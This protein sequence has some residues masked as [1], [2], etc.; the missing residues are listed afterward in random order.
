V[1]AHLTVQPDGHVRL[2]IVPLQSPVMTTSP[3]PA[4]KKEDAT[5]CVMK[6]GLTV[7]PGGRVRLCVAVAPAPPLRPLAA[8][9]EAGAKALR[10]GLA[11]AA[12]AVCGK[13]S[14][15]AAV[16]KAGG[17][18]KPAAAP[19]AGGA[20]KATASPVPAAQP[21]AAQAF[22][23]I[24]AAIKAPFAKARAPA[25]PAAADCAAGADAVV[26]LSAEPAACAKAAA[27]AAAAV[28]KPKPR[29]TATGREAR[30]RSLER[31]EE[32]GAQVSSTFKD[33]LSF[34]FAVSATA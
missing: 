2:A 34:H 27:S 20:R 25:A 14:K 1:A 6:A 10:T 4:A 23:K 31:L 12:E 11:R 3:K 17:S 28:P 21:K 24:A 13:A 15:A 8:A 9:I 22:S 16:L 29:A 5:P 26:L 33:T 32:F 19:A 7:L 30:R 18:A